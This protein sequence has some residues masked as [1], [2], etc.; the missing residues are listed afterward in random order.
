[1]VGVT[2]AEQV[3]V[4][5]VHPP[6]GVNVMVPAGIVAPVGLVSVTVAVQVDDCPTTTLVGEQ[7]IVV[8]VL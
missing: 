5:N 4:D 8:D 1:V 2:D 6:L 3:P 7:A